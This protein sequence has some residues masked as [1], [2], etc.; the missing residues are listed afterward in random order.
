MINLPYCENCGRRM[1]VGGKVHFSNE[2]HTN[3]G[4]DTVICPSKWCRFFHCCSEEHYYID[5]DS[6]LRKYV[7]YNEEKRGA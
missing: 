2:P 1:R 6:K 5:A 3:V 7:T 4:Y